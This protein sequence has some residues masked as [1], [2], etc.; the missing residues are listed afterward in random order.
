MI[1]EN[2]QEVALESWGDYRKRNDSIVVDLFHGQLKSTLVCPECA[3]V[4]IKFDP[5]CFLSLPL[6]QRDKEISVDVTFV[7]RDTAKKWTKV[8]GC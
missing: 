7:P 3:K 4:S 2:F 1:R 8:S 5:F 6:P